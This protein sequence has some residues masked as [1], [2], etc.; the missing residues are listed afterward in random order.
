MECR[1]I[2][3]LL[4]IHVKLCDVYVCFG[5]VFYKSVILA[6]CFVDI[7]INCLKKIG[8]MAGWLEWVG[9]LLAGVGGWMYV[10]IDGSVCWLVEFCNK[11]LSRLI[12]Y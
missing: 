5:L 1:K 7:S 12:S 8:W 3:F 2:T 10:R 9:G 6:D 11:K 4:L